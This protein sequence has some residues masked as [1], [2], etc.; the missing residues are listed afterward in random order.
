MRVVHSCTAAAVTHHTAIGVRD[1]AAGQTLA[2]RATAAE[3]VRKPG[4]MLRAIGISP[5]IDLI[6]SFQNLA[7]DGTALAELLPVVGFAVD[8]AVLLEVPVLAQQL[9]NRA[10]LTEQIIEV[11][12]AI[13]LAVAFIEAAAIERLAAVGADKV[14]GM[15]G[16]AQGGRV[17]SDYRLAA[18]G[19]ARTKAGVVAGFMIGLA[20]VRV[21]ARLADDLVAAGAAEAVGVPGLIQRRDG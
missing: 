3:A 7:A 4:L 13:R 10:A 20:L 14:R 18:A 6:T 5:G 8:L 12:L 1:A 15:P 16:F 17:F 21:E 11:A 19:A 9:A 2:D